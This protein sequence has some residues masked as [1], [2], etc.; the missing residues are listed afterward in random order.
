MSEEPNLDSEYWQ[1]HNIEKLE[2]AL[3]CLYDTVIVDSGNAELR[4]MAITAIDRMIINLRGESAVE[5]IEAVPYSERLRVS[6]DPKLRN[7]EQ[8]LRNF[9]KKDEE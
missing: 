5:K 4:G 7:L 6:E 9:F 1:Y 8:E 3:R 2:D